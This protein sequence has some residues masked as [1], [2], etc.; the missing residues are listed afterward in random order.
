MT[1]TPREPPQRSSV[2]RLRLWPVLAAAACALFLLLVALVNFLAD[3]FQLFRA[4]TAFVRDSN[5]QRYVNAGILRTGTDFDALVIG[6]SYIANFNTEVI[7]QLF[8]VR[9]R[10]IS[11]WGASQKEISETLRL[12]FAQHPDLKTVFLSAPVWGVCSDLDHP[13]WHLPVGL[14]RGE[15]LGYLPPLLTKGPTMLSVEKILRVTGL[16]KP[17]TEFVDNVA[18]VPRWDADAEGLFGSPERLRKAFADDA[19]K[20]KLIRYSPEQV[21]AGANDILLCFE[22]NVLA[23]AHAHPA[24]RFYVFNPPA[25]QWWLWARHRN[26]AVAVWNRAQ[27]ALA[28]IAAPDSNLAYF[29]FF[30]AREITNDCMRYRDM[31]HF[32]PRSGDELVT[33]MKADRYRRTPRTNDDVSQRVTANL[34]ELVPCPPDRAAQNAF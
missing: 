31:A 24:T 14:Y 4:G 9:S 5:Y 22:R 32:D 3:P 16:G 29:D 28:E 26:G 30:A 21:A 23:F 7:D 27:E 19:D 6:N 18:D 2:R 12:A 20:D 13:I 33:M 1:L 10:V 25:Y 17:A 8:G 15:P 34:G 11:V